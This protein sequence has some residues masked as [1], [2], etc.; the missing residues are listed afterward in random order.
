MS[1]LK[2]T[3]CTPLSHRP[4]AVVLM[5]WRKH[6]KGLNPQAHVPFW[7]RQVYNVPLLADTE[8]PLWQN[9]TLAM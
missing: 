4:Q 5:F 7:P 3:Y 9:S 8:K 6:S 1:V 2:T